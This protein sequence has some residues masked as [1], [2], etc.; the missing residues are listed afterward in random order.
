MFPCNFCLPNVVMDIEGSDPPV[1]TSVT[2]TTIITTTITTTT[3][4]I[5]VIIEYN[6]EI[7]IKYSRSMLQANMHN[8]KGIY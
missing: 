1:E 5:H 7:T 2:T 3:I 6:C 8:T 4:I